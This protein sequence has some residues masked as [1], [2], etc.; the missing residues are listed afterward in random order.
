MKKHFLIY[1]VLLFL[2]FEKA[3]DIFIALVKIINENLDLSNS[4]IYIMLGFSAIIPTILFFFFLKKL[5]FN[6]KNLILLVSIYILSFIMLYL[7]NKQIGVIMVDNFELNKKIN[8]LDI[9]VFG[10]SKTFMMTAKIIVLTTL[11]IRAFKGL[12]K[13]LDT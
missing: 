13:N 9:E 8:L 6:Y 11:S 5:K 7:L 4:I 12:N 3:C 1:G 10:W 2:L